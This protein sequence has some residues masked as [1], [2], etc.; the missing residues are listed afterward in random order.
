MGRGSL[1]QRG[2]V[3]TKRLHARNETVAAVHPN[4]GMTGGIAFA[5][6]YR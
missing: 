6:G 1:S 3:A 4:A 5:V 2:T